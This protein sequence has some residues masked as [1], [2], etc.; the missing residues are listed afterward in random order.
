MVDKRPQ[1]PKRRN[2]WIVVGLL[3]ALVLYIYIK[4]EFSRSRNINIPSSAVTEPQFR[5]DGKLF[6][7]GG[8]GDTL[9]HIDIEIADQEDQRMQGLMYRSKMAMDRGMLFIFDD[10]EPQTFW[11]KNT[12]IPLDIIY[13]SPEKKI[14]T[15]YKYTQPYSETP[16]PSFKP[17]MY[18]VEV[19]G[20][21]CNKYG[22]KEDDSIAFTRKR[23]LSFRQRHTAKGDHHDIAMR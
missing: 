14:V 20:G 5:N 18:V 21:F 11:M 19:N 13:I 3:A 23:A 22:I 7:L 12:K 9:A 6:F 15:I 2:V 16:I 10:T 1:S 4:N 8:T 17:A